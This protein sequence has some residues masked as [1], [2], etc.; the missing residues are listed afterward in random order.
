VYARKK[1]VNMSALGIGIDFLQAR[2]S[3]GLLAVPVPA[4][5]AQPWPAVLLPHT[6]AP[7]SL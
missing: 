4:P 3:A 6:H 7:L 1:G 2:G 5:C